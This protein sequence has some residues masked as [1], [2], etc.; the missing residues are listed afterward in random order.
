MR[1]LNS[2]I[3]QCFRATL[4]VLAFCVSAHVAFAQPTFGEQRATISASPATQSED[5]I[6]SLL[7][8]GITESKPTQAIAVTRR[9][10]RENVAENPLLLYHAGRAAELRG[11]WRGAAALYQQSLKRAELKSETATDALYAVYTLL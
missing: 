10:L 2:I 4:M 11:E 6:I 7:E 3:R 1:N 8:A 5:A 9:W